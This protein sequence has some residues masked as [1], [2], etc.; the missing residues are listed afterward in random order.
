MR[1]RLARRQSLF[2]SHFSLRSCQRCGGPTRR[3]RAPFC[4]L[5]CATESGPGGRFSNQS[6]DDNAWD[7]DDNG[8]DESCIYCHRNLR[9]DGRL[10]CGRRCAQSA[11]Q[12]A[13][14]ILPISENDPKFR[15]IEN[16][17]YDSWREPD[18]DVPT[19]QWISKIVQSKELTDRY[20]AYRDSVEE[21]GAFTLR[22]MAPGNECRR[23]HG[24]P[25]L[26]RI[27]EGPRRTGLCNN[28]ICGVCGIIDE[29]FRF[30]KCGRSGRQGAGF[31]RFGR[32]IYSSSTSSNS[33]YGAMLLTIVV[34]GTGYRALVDKRSWT[35]PP[36]R[37]HS[38]L[39]KV[40]V[41][42]KYDE[43][44]VYDE[45]AIRPSWLIVFR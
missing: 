10:Y 25:R 9:V 33:Q 30:D 24:T 37:W 36:P 4:S 43:T 40:G 7:D 5:Q 32:G 28:K 8:D 17:F 3:A 14:M 13:P 16:Q 31:Q 15:E 2:V 26:C 34:V 41:R 11:S 39:G 35:E 29:S 27:G 45:D 1:H 20:Y 22:G 19:V 42:L 21:E 38:V 18:K 6:Y 44:V 23:W 12:Q